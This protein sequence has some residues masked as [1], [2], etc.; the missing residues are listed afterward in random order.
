V[1]PQSDAGRVV[2]W[3]LLL[4]LLLLLLLNINLVYVA[5]WRTA[6]SPALCVCVCVEH[7]AFQVS[8]LKFKAYVGGVAPP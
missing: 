3:W 4:L 8:V 1:G 5:D 2:V 6:C 7:Q